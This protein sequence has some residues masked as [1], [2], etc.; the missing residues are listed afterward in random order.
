MPSAESA[1][2]YYSG[3][4]EADE[5]RYSGMSEADEDRYSGMS[6]ADED[7]YS[8][9]SEADEDQY[10]GMSEIDDVSCGEISGTVGDYYG[11]M[12]RIVEDYYGEISET[13]E[14]NTSASQGPPDPQVCHSTLTLTPTFLKSHR[15]L[16]DPVIGRLGRNRQIW[17]LTQ[18]LQTPD[19]PRT[20]HTVP[21]NI[22]W[23]RLTSWLVIPFCQC[24]AL[25]S[26]DSGC[27]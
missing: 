2:D 4:S 27:R 23:S 9:M 6:E 19:D 8:E 10:S 22:V 21:G 12:S 24:I 3:M 16:S 5:D 17:G 13:D 7:Q 18:V 11:E 25:N 14:A 26:N 20:H 15:S 1:E